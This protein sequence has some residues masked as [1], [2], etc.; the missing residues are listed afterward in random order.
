MKSCP[1]CATQ[2]QDLAPSCVSCGVAFGTVQPSWR[3][4]TVASA[5]GAQSAME[6]SPDLIAGRYRLIEQLGKGGAGVV[7][8]AWDTKLEEDI[9]IKILQQD[10]NADGAEIGRFK[11]EITTARKITHPNVIRIH[12]FGESGKDVFISMEILTGGTLGRRMRDGL[13]LSEAL[14]ISVGVCDGVQ[15]AHSLGIVHRDLKPDNILFANDGRPKV[16]DFGLARLQMASTRT[17][18]FSG[19]PFYMSPEHANGSE[20]TTRSDVYS[21]GIVFYQLFTGRIPFSADNFMRLVTMHCHESPPPPRQFAPTLPVELE[22]VLLKSLEKDPNRRH[23]NAGE[24]GSDLRKCLGRADAT[25]I[26]TNPDA[27]PSLRMPG[28]VPMPVQDLGPGG[29]R[30]RSKRP[31]FLG[32][33]AVVAVVLGGAA[34]SFSGLLGGPAATPIPT[35]TAVAIAPTPIVVATSTPMPTATPVA[36]TPA[37]TPRKTAT[38]AATRVA[39]R[40]TPARTA[41]PTPTPAQ[42]ATTGFLVVRG[43]DLIDVYVDGTKI[44]TAPYSGPLKPGAHVIKLMAPAASKSKTEPLSVSAG[45]TYEFYFDVEKNS[46]KVQKR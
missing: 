33:L 4:G 30:V 37:A 35:P 38:P 17:V 21:L 43:N 11:R 9:A 27:S 2:N 7:Y 6:S 10:E 16:V 8:R 24:L 15:A 40:P 29:A 3:G 39:V 5:S 42:A 25:V 45:K 28:P 31:L 12:D 22:R 41:A 20:V 13:A 32:V 44:G 23:A 18:G 1:S 19:T 46:V 26:R 14:S 36:A 34:A